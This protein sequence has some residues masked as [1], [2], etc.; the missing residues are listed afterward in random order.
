MKDTFSTSEVA[1]IFDINLNRLNNWL[2]SR[3]IVPSVEKASGHGSKNVFSFLDLF[4]ISLFIKLI[5]IGLSREAAS[6]I[7]NSAIK[8][9]PQKTQLTLAPDMPQR[10]IDRPWIIIRKAI[11]S[12][13]EQVA[14][15]LFEHWKYNKESSSR[16][17]SDFFDE[18]S[19]MI[20][21][22][23]FVF[24][25]DLSQILNQLDETYQSLYPG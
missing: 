24:I 18:I 4:R 21:G 20:G 23:E 12:G 2:G 5:N 10:Y 19:A 6:E 9:F 1:K 7:V 22:S 17:K 8:D 11:V 3:L 25:I 15:Q 13:K 14:A 16:F